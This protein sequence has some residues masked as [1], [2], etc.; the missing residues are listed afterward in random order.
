MAFTLIGLVIIL[1]GAVAFYLLSLP[2][3]EALSKEFKE[4]AVTKILGRKAQLDDVAEKA[5]NIVYHG[6][7][8]TFEYPA[9]AVVY[10]FKDPGFASSS[11]R[12]ED[13]SFDIRSPR[14]VFNMAVLGNPAG[15]MSIDD[16]PGVK[17]RQSRPD[18]YSE[19]TIT[20]DGQKGKVYSQSTEAEKTAFFL[21]KNKIYTISVTG[22]IFEE[23]KKLEYQ[24]LKSV[25]FK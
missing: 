12:L 16:N 17:L 3:R 18:L 20:V 9:K 14:L 10:T 24:V 22:T 19:E 6:Q 1:G 13:F 5:G 21:V 15:Q 8:I 2:P 23:V 4:K 7:N 11:S 25:K